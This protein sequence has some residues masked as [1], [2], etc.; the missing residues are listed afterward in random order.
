MT[1]RW[2]Y[3]RLLSSVHSQVTPAGA[4]Y[5][6]AGINEVAAQHGGVFVDPFTGRQLQR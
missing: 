1:F 3:H 6:E 2:T 5:S 4:V